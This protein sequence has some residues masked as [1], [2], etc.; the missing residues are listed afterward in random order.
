MVEHVLVERLGYSAASLGLW[1]IRRF[2]W[3]LGIQPALFGLILL[4]RREWALGG[5]SLGVAAITVTLSELLTTRRYRT[6]RK[7]RLPSERRA[8]RNQMAKDIS[9]TNDAP[10]TNEPGLRTRLSDS[11]MLRRVAALLPGYS[12]LPADCPLPLPT[13]EIDDMLFTEKASYAR[14]AFAKDYSQRRF[15]LDPTESI[16]GLIYPHAMLNPVPVIWLPNDHSGVASSEAA[17]LEVYHGLAAI[18]DPEE[19]EGDAGGAN[20]RGRRKEQG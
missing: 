14:P 13:Q 10:L 11:S 6:S 2:G 1:T 20:K 3:V 16:R 8:A 18:V 5:A 7:R 12:R 4:S 17:D 19:P 9:T 15:F